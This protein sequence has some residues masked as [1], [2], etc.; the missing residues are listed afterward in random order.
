LYLAAA[1]I[2]NDVYREAGGLSVRIDGV[3]GVG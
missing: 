3:R 2:L 1:F